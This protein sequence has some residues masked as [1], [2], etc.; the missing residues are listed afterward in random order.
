MN[1]DDSQS[2]SE[3]VLKPYDNDCANSLVAAVNGLIMKKEK[4]KEGLISLIRAGRRTAMLTNFKQ[5]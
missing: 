3:M 2:V 4:W 1:D 5:L